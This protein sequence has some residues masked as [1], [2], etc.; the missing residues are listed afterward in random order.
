MKQKTN[1]LHQILAVVGPLVTQSQNILNETIYTF[2]KKDSHF[3]GLKKTYAAI[4]IDAGD[5][6]GEDKEVVT[7]VAEKLKYTTKSFIPAVNALLSKEQTNSSGNAHATIS[8]DG[9]EFELSATSLLALEGQLTQFRNVLKTIPTLD[10]T[11]RWDVLKNESR[12]IL[13]TPEEKKI[14]FTKVQSPLLLAE[15]TKEHKAQ[16]QVVS[17]D[18]PAGTW[19]TLYLSGRITPAAKSDLLGRTD[20]LIFKVKKARSK[21][22]QADVVQMKIGQQVVDHIF[23]NT[24]K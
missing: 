7:T 10:P 9:K 19:N 22:N 17:T 23:G 3:D 21:A 13:V 14:R 2:Q 5:L 1:Q 8:L 12:A 11:R 15:A 6:P 24:I 20:D 16:V 4:D 18:K